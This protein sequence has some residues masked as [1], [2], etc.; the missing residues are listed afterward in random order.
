L[1]T[2]PAVFDLA[3]RYRVEI[4]ADM[5]DTLIGSRRNILDF[6]TA[7]TTTHLTE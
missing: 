7:H 1:N 5:A 2:T 6:L 4:D 3:P